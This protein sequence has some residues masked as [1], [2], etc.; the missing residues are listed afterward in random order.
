MYIFK[1]T[2]YGYEHPRFVSQ[3]EE[4]WVKVIRVV[5]NHRFLYCRPIMYKAYIITGL[6][7]FS[8]HKDFLLHKVLLLAINCLAWLT[9]SFEVV[10]I[11]SI[12]ERSAESWHR[13]YFGGFIFRVFSIE[14]GFY[15]LY[16]RL[17]ITVSLIHSS[18]GFEPLNRLTLMEGQI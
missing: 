4:L 9:Y 16:L 8:P 13:K 12:D 18:L 5:C 1:K 2:V 6:L 11:N 10:S 17:L 14:F 15:L 3:D 7:P